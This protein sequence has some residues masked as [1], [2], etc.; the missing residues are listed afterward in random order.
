MITRRVVRVWNMRWR[1]PDQEVGEEADKDWMMI[2]MVGGWMFLLVPAHPG[3]PGQRAVK[4]L[5]LLLQFTHTSSCHLPCVNLLP[6]HAFVDIRSVSVNFSQLV[7]VSVALASEWRT[8]TWRCCITPSPTSTSFIFTT[9]A[10]CP[11]SSPTA[12]SGLSAP[13]KTTC[14]TPGARLT[15]PAYSRWVCIHTRISSDYYHEWLTT[16]TSIVVN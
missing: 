16:Y 13:A 2:R 11:S 14:W 7:H 5:L 6:V 9:A 8:A 3:S 12:E 10:S 1:V 15:A 4:R